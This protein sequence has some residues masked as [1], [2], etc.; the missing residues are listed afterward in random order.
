MRISSG[1]N[2]NPYI[3]RYNSITKLFSKTQE[4]QNQKTEFHGAMSL[5]AKNLSYMLDQDMKANFA[6]LAKKAETLQT[7]VPGNTFDKTKATAVSNN[8]EKVDVTARNGAIQETYNLEVN[9]IATAQENTGKWLA[10]KDKVLGAGGHQEFAIETKQ[11]LVTKTA[12][13]TIE[14]EEDE[15]NKAILV[16]M[17]GKINSRADELGISAHVETRTV[18]GSEQAR[19]VIAGTQT[20]VDRNFTINDKEGTLSIDT[21]I[22]NI[23]TTA[24]NA[25][26]RVNG[27]TYESKTNQVNLD[28][29]NQVSAT[30]KGATVGETVK[31]EVKSGDVNSLYRDVRGFI[32]QYNQIAKNE[33]N[34]PYSAFTQIAAGDRKRLAAIGI[35][36]NP[37]KT[38]SINESRFRYSAVN[39]SDQVRE[40]LAAKNGFAAKVEAKAEELRK[41]DLNNP[42]SLKGYMPGSIF[43]F[44]I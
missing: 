40:T 34:N 11:G 23:T 2:I 41:A 3:N 7:T 20:G 32:D 30:L 16:K 12:N 21:G 33:G 10:A 22:N 26:Y 25:R 43:S 28:R 14:P 9:Q 36:I 6:D 24:Q 17:A 4:T 38:L 13:L 27:F 31:V 5:M 44:L 8:P 37:D 39:N 19:L 18:N 35:N 42:T 29:R 15:T 1:Y